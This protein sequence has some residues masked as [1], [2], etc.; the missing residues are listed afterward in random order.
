MNFMP[1]SLHM[2]LDTV[3]SQMPCQV[4]EIMMANSPLQKRDFAH[5]KVYSQQNKHVKIG[6]T[7]V[8][9]YINGNSN[10]E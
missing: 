9:C 5:Q 2:G 7:F 3:P 6:T 10:K 4:M 1:Q 8:Y